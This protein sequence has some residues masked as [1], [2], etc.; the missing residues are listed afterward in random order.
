MPLL[1]I[2]AA[3]GFTQQTQL[4]DA[5]DKRQPLDTAGHRRHATAGLQHQTI[6]G[7]RRIIRRALLPRRQLLASLLQRVEN[8]RQLGKRLLYPQVHLGFQLLALPGLASGVKVQTDH[9]NGH[10][11]R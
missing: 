1:I 8:H 4:Q 9:P 2:A 10:G 11:Q 6:E 7:L 3:T 5:V